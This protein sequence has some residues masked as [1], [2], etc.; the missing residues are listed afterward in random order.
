MST[1]PGV[2]CP[3]RRRLRSVAFVLLGAACGGGDA[4]GGSAAADAEAPETSS[5]SG[6]RR[7]TP[8]PAVDARIDA[9]LQ[10][11]GDEADAALQLASTDAGRS[12]RELLAA[13]SP[14]ARASLRR[15]NVRIG[16]LVRHAGGVSR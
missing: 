16:Q 5:S 13:L 15:H 6:T 9:V 14:K 11:L 7:G 4:T 1:S 12:R 10:E 8:M 2:A 3:L